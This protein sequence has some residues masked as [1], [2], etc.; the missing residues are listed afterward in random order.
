MWTQNIRHSTQSVSEEQSQEKM[1]I[2]KYCMVGL[3]FMEYF[4]QELTFHLPLV[5][6]KNSHVLECV[7]NAK[8]GNTWN[9]VW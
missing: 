7:K 4:W 6:T 8:E 9:V 1:K 5:F 3:P 2:V